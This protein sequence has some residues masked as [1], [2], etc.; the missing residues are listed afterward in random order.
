MSSKKI[1]LSLR[2][3]LSFSL[4]VS[5]LDAGRTSVTLIDR[6]SCVQ[7][8]RSP[9]ALDLTLPATCSD[10]SHLARVDAEMPALPGLHKIVAAPKVPLNVAVKTQLASDAAQIRDGDHGY[11]S[12]SPEDCRRDSPKKRQILA[13]LQKVARQE[14]AVRADPVSEAGSPG[15]PPRSPAM[16]K[17]AAKV[18]L[19]PM[20]LEGR[21]S[22]RAMAAMVGDQP[23]ALNH[24]DSTDLVCNTSTVQSVSTLLQQVG[25][26]GSANPWQSQTVYGGSPRRYMPSEPLPN[27]SG[28][29][30]KKKSKSK[31]P[32]KKQRDFAKNYW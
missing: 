9:F 27:Y 5:Q 1:V 20:C 12:P 7:T 10:S 6:S 2:G 11:Q 3:V 28:W 15:S 25:A 29:G 23:S 14:A 30:R 4:K 26:S 22:P 21:H 17:A 18:L 32:A 31:S 13:A 8:K 19:E 24:E 16:N